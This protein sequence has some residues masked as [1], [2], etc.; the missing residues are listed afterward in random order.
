MVQVHSE[1]MP[2]FMH[3]S[4]AHT[5]GQKMI[6]DLQGVRSHSGYTYTLTDPVLLSNHTHGG[7]YGCTDTGV[8]GMAMF[9][10]KHTCG[11]FCW[12]YPKPTP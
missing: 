12:Q 8:E 6:A 7:Q 1:L 11:H 4:W 10:L 3:W 5:G 2:A 9:F